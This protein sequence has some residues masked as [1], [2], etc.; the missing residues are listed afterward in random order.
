[1]DSLRV[2]C[3]MYLRNIMNFLR[4]LFPRNSSIRKIWYYIKAITAAYWYRFPA[5]H[6]QVI[7]ITGTD[8][9]TTTVEMISHVLQEADVQHVKISTTSIFINGKNSPNTTKRT[10]LSP[11]YMQRL[12]REAVQSGIKVAVI[13][14]SS[15]A[16][17]QKRIFGVEFDIA[18]ITNV[19]EGHVDDHGSFEKYAN[20]KKLL[21]TKYLKKDGTAILNSDDEVVNSWKEDISAKTTW[22]ASSDIELSVPGDFNKENA[23]LALEVTKTLGIEETVIRKALLGFNGVSGRLEKIDC[24]QNFDIYIDFAVTTNALK[25]A[26]SSTQKLTEKNLWVVFGCYGDIDRKRRPEMGKLAGEDC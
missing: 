21:F 18:G 3:F 23:D 15:H 9:K 6:L 22:Y 11:W 25:N 2:E 13:E 14:V 1:M 7:G 17:E 26:L 19:T 16:T 10:S 12:L 8:G 20:A 24:G 5:K 4:H